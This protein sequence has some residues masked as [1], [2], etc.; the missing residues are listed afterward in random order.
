MNKEIMRAAGFGKQ[1]DLIEQG[2]CPLCEETIKMNFKDE[3]SLR[4]FNISGM[5]QKC[6]DGFFTGGQDG[7]D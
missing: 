4:E 1:V 7:E 5:C 6:Q 3:I 2:K